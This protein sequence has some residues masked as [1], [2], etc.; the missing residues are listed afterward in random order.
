MTSVPE[1]APADGDLDLEFAYTSWAAS[2]RDPSPTLQQCRRRR[3]H[4]GEHAAG[5]GAARSRWAV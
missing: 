2:C 1:S 5:F 4:D 3:G